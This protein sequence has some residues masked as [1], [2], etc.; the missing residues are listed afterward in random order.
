MGEAIPGVTVV[1]DGVVAAIAGSAVREVQGVYA[2]GA[3]SI[4][5]TLA[6]HVGAAKERTRDVDVQVGLKEAIVDLS[7]RVIY[8]FSIPQIASRIRASVAEK[9]SSLCGLTC[10]EVNIRVVGIGFL[11]EEINVEAIPKS[12]VRT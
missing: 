5:R 7:V 3:S 1:A 2:L 8:G 6:E 11:R 9:L 12:E 10:K 4:G